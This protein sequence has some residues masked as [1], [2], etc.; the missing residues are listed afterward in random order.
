MG[1]ASRAWRC[2]RLLVMCSPTPFWVAELMVGIMLCVFVGTTAVAAGSHITV[3]SAARGIR[4]GSESFVSCCGH[5]AVSFNE[6][7]VLLLSDSLLAR[8]V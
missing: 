4:M 8:G 1:M 2:H 5:T 3:F 7:C 6:A